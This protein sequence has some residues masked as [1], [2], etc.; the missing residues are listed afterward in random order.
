[1]RRGRDLKVSE[2]Y[3]SLPFSLRLPHFGMMVPGQLRPLALRSSGHD[4]TA[5]TQPNTNVLRGPLLQW[6]HLENNRYKYGTVARVFGTYKI[7]F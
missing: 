6:V 5:W 2:E 4:L 1:M 7:I 3:S